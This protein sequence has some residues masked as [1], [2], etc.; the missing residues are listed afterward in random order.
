ME[1]SLLVGFHSFAEV[2]GSRRFE[3]HAIF[4]G[5]EHH[6]SRRWA[7]GK[8]NGNGYS[9]LYNFVQARQS[10]VTNQELTFGSHL[11][12]VSLNHWRLI[13][14]RRP[15]QVNES[16]KVAEETAKKIETAA[17]AYKPCAV[18]A[19][20]LY[21]V[22]NE[23]ATID[24]MYQFSLDAYTD[25]FHISIAKSPKSDQLQTRIKNLN[26]FHTFAVRK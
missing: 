24:P 1:H 5:L 14:L 8:G 7:Q 19:S 13:A 20:A 23:L 26:D 16:L 11:S 21:F 6:S 2:L 12:P 17:A 22:L 9:K 25:L 4:S 18:R 15:C 3:W 10:K